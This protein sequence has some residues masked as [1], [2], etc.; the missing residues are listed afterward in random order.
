[1]SIQTGTSLNTDIP[2]L[3]RLWKQAFGDEDACIDA[4][5]NTAYTPERVL[6]LREDGQ[7]R[8]MAC[9][10]PMTVC[11]ASRG[12]PAGYLYA[13]STEASARGR[14]FCRQLLAFAEEFLA[15][16]GI[17]VLLLVPGGPSLRQFYRRCGYADFTTV[18]ME[19]LRVTA[20]QGQAEPIAAPEYLELREQLL[21]DRPY[22]SCPVPVLEFQDALARLYGGGLVRLSGSGTEG[23]ACVAR[24]AGGRAV[25]Y[26]LL[27]PGDRAEGAS[28]A[29]GL[30]GAERALVRAPGSTTPFA[31]ANWLIKQPECRPPYLGL[32]LD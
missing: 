3:R 32:A 10:L 8:A 29:A 24:D 27:W 4:F 5:F 13:V 20:A 9:W 26:E 21:S 25:V 15:A 16:R 2:A 30:V 17:K 28:L 11:Q 23:C 7:V 22:V 18:D 12:W 31:M 14:G 6:V 1:M 19:E